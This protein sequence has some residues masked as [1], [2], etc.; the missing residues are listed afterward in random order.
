M[1]SRQTPSLSQAP[2]TEAP[3]LP[4]KCYPKILQQRPFSSRR[5]PRT[6]VRQFQADIQDKRNLMPTRALTESAQLPLE[7]IAPDFQVTFLGSGML[8]PLPYLTGRA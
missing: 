1:G 5:T 4:L 7:S 8:G 6:S 2:R 3:S